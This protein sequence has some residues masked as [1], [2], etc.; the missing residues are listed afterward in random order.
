[1]KY[2]IV[3]GREK[4]ETIERTNERE[5]A[6]PKLTRP[7]EPAPHTPRDVHRFEAAVVRGARGDA[8]KVIATAIPSDLA[9]TANNATVRAL[10]RKTVAAMGT[11][12]EPPVSQ[13]EEE[14][15]FSSIP[16]GI[17]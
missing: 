15:R 2:S 5:A 11:G 9:A 10:I 3:E 4:P 16:P 7:R 8:V 12:D 13:R 14:S 1:M 17:P 6:A